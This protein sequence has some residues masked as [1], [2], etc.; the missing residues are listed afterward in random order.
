MPKA[1]IT[2]ARLAV[3]NWIADNPYKCQRTQG[4]A[5]CREIAKATDSVPEAVYQVL[6]KLCRDGLVIKEADPKHPYIVSFKVNFMHLDLPK[7]VRD[8][9]PSHIQEV[10]ESTNE[11]LKSGEYLSVDKYGAGLVKQGDPLA[12]DTL[13]KEEEANLEEQ[14]QKA[15]KVTDCV[16]TPVLVETK[17]PVEVAPTIIKSSDG[18]TI[19]INLTINLNL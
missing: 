15:A 6:H 17:P 19:S 12:A 2:K 13:T 11:K 5:I 1:I 9:A 14:A 8:K 7:E 10:A 3:L 4:M 16:E 18:K